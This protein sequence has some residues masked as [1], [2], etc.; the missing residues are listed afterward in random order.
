M[1]PRTVR[2]KEGNQ[3][4]K[5]FKLLD[6]NLKMYEGGSAAA[7]AATS[8]SNGV[9]TQQ[10][11][12]KVVY[13]KQDGEGEVAT[14]ETDTAEAPKGDK[15]PPKVDK[16]PFADLIKGDYKEDFE[17]HIKSIMDRRFKKANQAESQ[18]ATVTP[19]LSNLF[20]KYNVAEGDYQALQNA[21]D[22]DTAY[23]EVEAEEKGMSVEQLQYVKQIERQVAAYKQQQDTWEADQQAKAIYQKWQTESQEMKADY[24]DFDFDK[25]V[26]GNQDFVSM[27][28]SGVPVKHAYEVSHLNDI[29]TNIASSTAKQTEAQVVD[30]IKAKGQRPSEAGLKAKA[31]VIVKSDVHSFTKEDRKNIA[32]QV[33]AG[34]KIKL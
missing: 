20:S 9:S 18:L 26:A 33:L 11:A 12:P 28:K 23:L 7:P 17:N 15:E 34:E 13:G 4:P 25:E 27:I 10:A 29:K 5:L 19:L 21:M 22:K 1:T 24:P 8:A 31:G 3:M 16:K 30:N 6:V 14:P 2:G 32:K